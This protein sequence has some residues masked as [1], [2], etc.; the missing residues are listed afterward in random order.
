MTNA[1]KRKQ[2]VRS[3]GK[4][5]R[6]NHP[7][8]DS[9]NLKAWR[10]RHPKRAAIM[11]RKSDLK[12]FYKLSIE[13]YSRMVASQNGKCAICHEVPKVQLSVDHSHKSGKNRGLLCQACNVS[14]GNMRDNPLRLRAAAEYLERYAAII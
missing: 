8:Q 10:L 13:E 14:L 12:R 2:Q 9:K 7:G 4:R 5:W 11:N 3:A 6:E 1:E